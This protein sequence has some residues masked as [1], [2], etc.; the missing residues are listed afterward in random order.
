M[1]GILRRTIRED[2]LDPPFRSASFRDQ[3]GAV[4]VSDDDGRSGRSFDG[5]EHDVTLR[6]GDG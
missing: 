6:A 4:F 3:R 1:F 2:R 5:R